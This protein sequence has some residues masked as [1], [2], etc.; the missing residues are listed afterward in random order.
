MEVAREKHLR[1]VLGDSLFD[2]VAAAKLL[3]VG[4]GGI[5][6]EVLKDL[7]LSGFNDIEVVDL[8][9]IDVSNLN[10]QFL[11]RKHH[12]KKPKGETA[13]EAVK[14]FNP[15]ASVRAHFGNIKDPKFGTDFYSKFTLCINGLDNPSARRHV[16]HMCLATGLPMLDGGSTGFEAQVTVTVKGETECYDC[17]T[18]PKPKV[19]P[20]CT[21]RNTPDQPIHCIVWAK[22][23]YDVLF[24]PA[25]DSNVLRDVKEAMDE[26]RA[27]GNGDAG[28]LLF[29]HLF[30]QEIV[31]QGTLVELW[32]AARPAPTPLTLTEARAAKGDAAGKSVEDAQ[33]VWSLQRLA[34]LFVATVK[35]IYAHRGE[36]I[37]TLTFTKD[38]PQ[39]IDFVTAAANIRMNNYRIA[40]QSRW[41][42]QSMAGS[43][44]PAVASTNA[45]LSALIVQQA[46]HILREGELKRAATQARQAW[47]RYEATAK[48]KVAMGSQLL[49]PNPECHACSNTTV[50]VHVSSV[51]EW[52]INQLAKVVLCG[53]LGLSQPMVVLGGDM[54][55]DP[56]FPEGDHP[57]EGAHPEWTLKQWG[58]DSSK[59][60][61]VMD[62]TQKRDFQLVVQEA[63]EILEREEEFPE[64][65]FIGKVLPPRKAVESEEN[66]AKKL[67]TSG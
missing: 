18:R 26:V 36:E 34:D 32:S 37:G 48:G 60:L 66:P 30:N 28:E 7:V 63:P 43:I 46:L 45:I 49:G 55:Y 11:F 10:R 41:T 16:N 61:G 50:V 17:V 5:G 59:V 24:G 8:D 58:V 64:K 51:E 2:K 44:I 22:H 9:T 57:E 13:A 52:R 35:A 27:N 4:A 1:K 62:D 38:D 54:I 19:Y 56:E 12:V 29:D 42:V 6:C 33:V 3:V 23:L 15:A 25:D 65:Y 39:C 14:V 47:I 20:V 53:Q 67:K 40:M 31:K 21:I